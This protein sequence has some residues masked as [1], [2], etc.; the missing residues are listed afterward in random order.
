MS[1]SN[2]EIVCMYFCDLMLFVVVVLVVVVVVV[3]VVALIKTDAN[4]NTAYQL[5][6][7]LLLKHC[8]GCFFQ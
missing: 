5:K 4:T 2:T 6:V 7:D 1:I 3:V 8:F